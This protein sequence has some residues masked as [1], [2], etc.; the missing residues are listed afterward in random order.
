MS[1]F[2]KEP[3]KPYLTTTPSEQTFQSAINAE[4]IGQELQSKL[5]EANVL[6]IPNRGYVDEPCQPPIFHT[7]D[8]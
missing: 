8:K 3:K 6:F 7:R 5:L 4:F 2:E 1:L